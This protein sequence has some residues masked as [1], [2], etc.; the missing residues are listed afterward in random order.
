MDSVSEPLAFY[1]TPFYS[2]LTFQASKRGIFLAQ[3]LPDENR[4]RMSDIE[5]LES[6]PEVTGEEPKFEIL[7]TIE[8]ASRTATNEFERNND[9]WVE[10]LRNAPPEAKSIQVSSKGNVNNENYG[11]DRQGPSTDWRKASRHQ[12]AV[13][14]PQKTNWQDWSSENSLSPP[15]FQPIHPSGPLT[16]N[17]LTATLRN[18]ILKH[19][20]SFD[21]AWRV[22]HRHYRQN[23]SKL[24]QRIRPGRQSSNAPVYMYFTRRER[25]VVNV[26]VGSY[27]LLIIL[28]S[29]TTVS[30]ETMLAFGP[31][32]MSTSSPAFLPVALVVFVLSVSASIRR[33][34]TRA[35]CLELVEGIVG[36]GCVIVL[37]T[38][39]GFR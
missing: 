38:S 2:N 1:H 9:I 25:H 28:A 39:F 29:T 3:L 19:I 16:L 20:S 13:Q 15:P 33:F 11:I 23:G 6:T 10:W 22:R 5:N 34:C 36:S 26:I 14:S 30:G 12:P 4:N 24:R 18:R 35:T 8:L 17:N 31:H 27:L 37:P 7:V 32:N 21:I